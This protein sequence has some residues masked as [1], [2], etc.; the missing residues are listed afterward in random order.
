MDEACRELEVLGVEYQQRVDERGDPWLLLSAKQLDM[1]RL[2][3]LGF[4]FGQ[5][6]TSFR[7]LVYYR[8]QRVGCVE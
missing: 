3:S 2:R 1:E 6:C 8:D 5:G 7:Y 4:R